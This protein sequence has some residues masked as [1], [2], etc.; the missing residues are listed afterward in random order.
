VL[1][2]LGPF[3]S[4]FYLTN[5]VH[6]LSNGCSSGNGYGNG[7]IQKIFSAVFDI[8]IGEGG[9]GFCRRSCALHMDQNSA[10]GLTVL[11]F[12]EKLSGALLFLRLISVRLRAGQQ[13]LLTL[14]AS[15]NAGEF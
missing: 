13:H 7:S 14:H 9:S 6:A 1:T 10:S 2:F 3:C 11:P 15:G 12:F 8:S 4:H 5:T